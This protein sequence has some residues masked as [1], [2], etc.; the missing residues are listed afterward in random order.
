MGSGTWL[1]NTVWHEAGGNSEKAE[2]TISLRR[3]VYPSRCEALGF[4]NTEIHSSV[5]LCSR[6][7]ELM[8]RQDELQDENLK[9]ETEAFNVECRNK[10]EDEMRERTE[11]VEASTSCGRSVSVNKTS[12]KLELTHPLYSGH[13]WRA[14]TSSGG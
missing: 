1:D 7:S 4:A 2:S 3:T 8:P 12:K 13:D 5:P 6:T 14:K 10:I 9:N 11:E